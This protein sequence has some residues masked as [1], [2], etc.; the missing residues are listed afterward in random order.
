MKL[1][2]RMNDYIFLP[3]KYHKQ[4]QQCFDLVC[5]IEEF[6][7]KEEYRY[8]KA[9]PFK[10]EEK[11]IEFFKN[12]GH[13][14][15]FLQQYGK[16]EDMELAV[17]HQVLYALIID[18]CYFMQEALLCSMKMRLVVTYSLLRR[19]LIDDLKIALKLL[20]DSD[21]ADNFINIEGYDPTKIK[22][23]DLKELLSATD[24][25]RII[26][27]IKGNDIYGFVFDKD[28]PNSILNLSNQALHPIT[29][30]NKKNL[31]G[32]M[33]LNFMFANEEN[34]DWMWNCL[35]ATLLPVLMYYTEI[36][37]LCIV[38]YNSE[39]LCEYFINDRYARLTEI[40]QTK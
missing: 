6:I 17:K 36:F 15:D 22:D 26:S 39:R 4:H 34:N 23:E 14:F 37:N 13:P 12:G 2:K 8:L 7:I 35:Y 16:K 29:N 30:R 10:I 25:I 9:L 33:N 21:F 28:N 38:K 20:A 40:L 1:W 24:E 5:Q 3:D 27:P 32:K 19:P 11:D 31:T 18:F